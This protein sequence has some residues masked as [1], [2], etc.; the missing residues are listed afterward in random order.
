MESLIL[1]LHS[2][3]VI[4]LIRVCVQGKGESHDVKPQPKGL[5]SQKK[6]LMFSV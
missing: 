1:A 4:I 5:F 3:C 2:S 6:Q